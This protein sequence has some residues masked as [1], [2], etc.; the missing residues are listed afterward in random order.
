MRV[1]ARELRIRT[2]SVLAEVQ[3]GREV[4]ITYRRKAVAVLKPL[5]T[6]RKA[7]RPLDPIGFGLWA[8]RKDLGDVA[9]WLRKVRRPR[10]VR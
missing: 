1:G 9:G 3:R 4:T 2:A 10:Y 8:D 5:A 6:R 7:S